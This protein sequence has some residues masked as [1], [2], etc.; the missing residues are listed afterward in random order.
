MPV[1]TL[2]NP[3]PEFVLHAEFNVRLGAL[4]K[5][6]RSDMAG[7]F[8]LGEFSCINRSS[9]G[10]YCGMG[11]SSY[12]AD[13]NVG[14][15]CTFGSRLS[16]GAFDHPTDWLSIHE[17]Q[18]R[19]IGGIYGETIL[20]GGVNQLVDGTRQTHIG[21]D[22]WIGDNA[23]V[24][25]GVTIGHGVIIGMCAVVTRDVEPYSI[26]VGNPG[27]VLR[28]RFSDKAVTDLL[29]LKWWEMNMQAL[30]G[31]DYRNI[32][33]AIGELKKRRSETRAAG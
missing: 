3:C 16:I 15:Y 12:A 5:I 25:R 1:I 21:S 28:K 11:S 18:Y 8:T 23:A 13:T 27:R 19:D 7:N 20:D 32:D 6:V 33:R 30:K 2:N 22:V 9:F 24:K 14:R 29:E 31:V 4:S 26:V 10:R 17:F